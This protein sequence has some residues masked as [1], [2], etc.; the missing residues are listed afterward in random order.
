[1]QHMILCRPCMEDMKTSGEFKQIKLNRTFKEKT[2][3]NKCNRRRF[4]SE[5]MLERKTDNG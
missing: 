2:T 1:M 3:C 4:A 5:Y